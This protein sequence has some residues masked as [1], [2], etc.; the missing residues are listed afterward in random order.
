MALTGGQVE[1]LVGRLEG[2]SYT[3]LHQAFDRVNYKHGPN[4]DLD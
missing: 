3:L 1:R 2:L 4:R